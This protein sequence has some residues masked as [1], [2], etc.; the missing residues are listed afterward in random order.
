M[1]KI[2]IIMMAVLLVGAFIGMAAGSVVNPNTLVEETIGPFDSM[3]PAWA[4]DT[5]SGE[6]IWQLYENLVQYDGTSTVN[7]LP[8]LSTNV[9]SVADGTI[10]DNGT[11]Y[12]F[13]IR[14]GVYFHNGDIL[15]P[16]DVVY[17]LERTVIFDRA[18]GPSWMLA[19]P[20]FPMIDGQY[21]STIVQVVANEL[22]LSNPLNYTSLSSLGIFATGTKNPLSDKYK[23]ALIN[24]F[25]L[26]AK[27]F[28]IKG[29]DVIIHLPQ[30]YAPFLYILAHG[31]N[32]S[33]ILDKKWAADHNAWDGAADDWWYYHNPVESADPLRDIENGTG[34]YQLQYWIPGREMAFVRFDNYWG[35]PAPVKYAVIKYVNEFTTRLLDLLSGQADVIYVPIENLSEVEN[36]PNVRV[37]TKLPTLEVDNIYF[38]WN[39]ASQGNSY[40]GSGK[41]DGNGIPPD[42]FSN[43]DVRKAFEYLFPYK[44]YIQQA[45]NGNAMQP[46][47]CIIEGLLG[48][49]P[50]IPMYQQDLAKATEYFKKAYN[51]ELWQKG[52]K[53]TA[54]YNTGNT[55]RQLALQALSN[56]ARQIN[57]KF[58]INVVGE[59]WS[60]FLN[61]YL[62]GK[63]PMYMMGW[64]ADYPDPYDFADAYFASTGAYGSA[65]G[66]NFID[67]AQK[68]LDPLVNDLITNVVPSQRAAIAQKLSMLSYENALYIWTDQPY[69][70]EVQR[71]WVKGW[72]YNAM[73]PG[74]DFY[75]LSK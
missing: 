59:L 69:A 36:N 20:L 67:F 28:E 49:D 47:S 71:T 11:T 21:V 70:Y 17:S 45:W 37:I 39:I 61:D 12:V 4:Y 66:Q 29:N 25:N 35:K 48:Y 55:T 57:P 9:P 31:A 33:S 52:F 32:W 46:N 30:P 60:N 54:V 26:L 2:L 18:G 15:T 13:H 53:F 7:L 68:N 44:Q 65:L 1:K 27:D 16:E 75:S 74:I 64:L 41:L 38:T 8:M 10:L 63:L 23:Q 24:A 50:N 22:G 19:G 34:P 72:Y 73:R 5:A 62:A 43:L 51:G 3:D 42:F 58:Q 56:Y 40:I 6:V 14:Q